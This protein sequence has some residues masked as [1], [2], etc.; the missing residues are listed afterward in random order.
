MFKV[1]KAAVLA[2]DTVLAVLCLYPQHKL[3]GR[4]SMQD[5][6]IKASWAGKEIAAVQG[7]ALVA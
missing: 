2:A 7:I 3:S 1:T 5:R 4:D 6:F